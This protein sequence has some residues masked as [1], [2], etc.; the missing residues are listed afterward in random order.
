[1]S[2]RIVFPVL[3][4]SDVFG[5]GGGRLAPHEGEDMLRP[6]FDFVAEF[7]GGVK[8]VVRELAEIMAALEDLYY[9]DPHPLATRFMASGGER[10]KELG[11]VA[12]PERLGVLLGRERELSRMQPGL[13]NGG[14]ERPVHYSPPFLSGKSMT[15]S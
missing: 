12:W 3:H 2:V 11:E 7:D 14:L 10:E 1:M 13:F 8:R 9:L 4:P 6:E 15:K 5:P